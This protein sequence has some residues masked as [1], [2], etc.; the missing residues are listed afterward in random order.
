MSISRFIKS[1]FGLQKILRIKCVNNYSNRV[2]QNRLQAARQFSSH[3]LL[4]PYSPCQCRHISLF[5]LLGKGEGLEATTTTLYSGASSFFSIVQIDDCTSKRFTYGEL[6]ELSMRVAAGLSKLGFRPG[7][8]AGVHCGTK[9]EMV[10][11]FNG[12]LFS[13]GTVVFAK[14]NLTQSEYKHLT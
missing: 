8:V 10:F 2:V 13:G 6:G 7:Q 1:N 11:A 12:V 14:P 9:P 5:P 4:A 3:F